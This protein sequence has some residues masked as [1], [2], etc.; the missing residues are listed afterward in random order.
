MGVERRNDRNGWPSKEL[1]A[2][3]SLELEETF[4]GTHLGLAHKPPFP[5]SR[6]AY[7]F[8]V[9]NEKF[10]PCCLTCCQGMFIFS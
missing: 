10:L 7:F 8:I 6:L 5:H 3:V 9:K 2:V 1:L 4:S